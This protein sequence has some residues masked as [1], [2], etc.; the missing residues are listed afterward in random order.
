MAT[1]ATPDEAHEALAM[2]QRTKERR[3]YSVQ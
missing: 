3:G 1:Y 2:Q